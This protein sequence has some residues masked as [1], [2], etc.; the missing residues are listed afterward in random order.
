MPESPFVDETP[1]TFRARKMTSFMFPS[2]GGGDG[3][4]TES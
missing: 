1:M 4:K 3:K 2:R